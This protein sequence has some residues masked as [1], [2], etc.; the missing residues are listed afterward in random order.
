[1][2]GKITFMMITIMV[3]MTRIKDFKYKISGGDTAR[4]GEGG[5]KA[6]SGGINQQTFRPHSLIFICVQNYSHHQVDRLRREGEEGRRRS[7]SQEAHYRTTEQV[8]WKQG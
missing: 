2:I 8:S 4:A 3:I 7:S 1:M 6:A 5:G